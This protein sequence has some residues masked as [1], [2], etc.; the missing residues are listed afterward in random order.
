MGDCLS[1]CVN[2]T[3]SNGTNC[4]VC[5]RSCLECKG[6]DAYNC[7][8]CGPNFVLDEK[9]VCLESKINKFELIEVNNPY[10]FALYIDPNPNIEVDQYYSILN[11]NVSGFEINEYDYQIKSSVENA[12]LIYF[13]FTFEKLVDI[14]SFLTINMKKSLADNDESNTISTI[15]QLKKTQICVD[16]TFLFNGSCVISN[17]EYRPIINVY[18]LET[19][20]AQIF[21]IRISNGD[22]NANSIIIEFLKI[23][24]QPIA[25]F[26][27]KIERTAESYD[28]F[29][30]T[31]NFTNALVGK[32]IMT[33]S[34]DI[35]EDLKK[36]IDRNIILSRTTFELPEIYQLSEADIQTVENANSFRNGV[37]NAAVIITAVSL[38]S[39]PTFGSMKLLVLSITLCR[40]KYL[41]VMFYFFVNI[42]LKYKYIYVFLKI[43]IYYFLINIFFYFRLII[44]LTCKNFSK[45]RTNSFLS[46]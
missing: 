18:I 30:M 10:S 17:E 13:Y 16:G 36:K 37:E 27:Y 42:I 31:L 29:D 25:A 21:K 14:N 1:D 44:L 2:G 15:V 38:V 22:A 3:F 39:F 43:I 40:L 5:H 26:S 24:I 33:I 12:S 4:V 34:M 28:K 32:Y 6:P 7:T 35:P 8:K 46:F 20:D 45:R 19:S 41:T 9:G 11:L 23:M